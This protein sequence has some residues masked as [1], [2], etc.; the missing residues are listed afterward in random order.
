MRKMKKIK[1]GII[2][3]GLLGN[4]H[5]QAIQTI[6]EGKYLPND[7][8]VSV[9]AVCDT[10][11][12]HV[13]NYAKEWD[14]EH[15]CIDWRELLSLEEINTVYISTPT[16]SHKEIFIAATDAGKQIFIQKPL[17]FTLDDIQEMIAARDRNN[18]YVQVGH[19][20]RNHPGIWTVRKICR[21]PTYRKKMG[22]LFNIHFRSD[23]EKPYTGSGF[24]PSTWRRDKEQAHAGTLYEHSIHDF[25]MIRFWFDD[26]YKFHE[27][28]AI[29]KYFFEVEDI[30]DSVGV[31]AE[32]GNLEGG[33]GAT[34][35]L[36]AV[37]H[38]VHRD[39]RHIEIFWENAHLEFKYSLLKFNGFLEIVGED[40]IEFDSDEMDQRY[41]DAIGYGDSPSIWLQNYGYETLLFLDSLVKG[42]AH[43]WTAKLEDSMRAHQIVE[44]CYK[45][46]RE[47]RTIKIQ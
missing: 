39:A 40:L 6:I 37:W 17:T 13:I 3:V 46:S 47:H 23:Q 45:S 34:F 25:D 32:L 20:N 11:E 7:V 2:G 18:V 1:I 35:A 30:E 43:P 29:A 15:A 14:I 21:D 19:S 42:K 44:A 26:L 41:R 33:L 5:N 31:L 8:E 22:R 16:V 4:F 38:N 24:H 10:R 28:Y 9:E 12:D 36:T 27:V